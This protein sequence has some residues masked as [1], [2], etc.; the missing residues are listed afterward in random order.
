MTKNYEGKTTIQNVSSLEKV[1]NRIINEAIKGL[2]HGFFDIEI[3][4][5]SIGNGTKRQIT[6]KV[7]KTYR[8]TIPTTE[9][10]DL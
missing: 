1:K 7:G 5:E 9:L 8:F 10:D 6:L 4:G 3:H 2:K